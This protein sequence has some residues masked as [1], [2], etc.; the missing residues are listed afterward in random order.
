MRATPAQTVQYICAH[1]LAVEGA[2]GPGL[3]TPITGSLQLLL[4]LLEQAFFPFP[5][6][7]QA[8]R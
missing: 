7:L 3:A 6:S 8:G 2:A 4:P 1:T 5:F